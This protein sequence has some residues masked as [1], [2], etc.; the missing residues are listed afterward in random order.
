M[1]RLLLI[2]LLSTACAT[3]PSKDDARVDGDSD[4]K[5]TDQKK[6]VAAEKPGQ[7][8]GVHQMDMA[9]MMAQAAKQAQVMRDAQTACDSEIPDT[10]TPAQVAE[11]AKEREAAFVKNTGPRLDNAAAVKELTRIGSA[12]A[13]APQLQ[14]GLVDRDKPRAFSASDGTVLV[15]T[16]LV[17]KCADD[18]PL[19]VCDPKMAS[20]TNMKMSGNAKV[21]NAAAGLRQKARFS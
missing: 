14:F 16:G 18:T 21:K 1:R 7:S 8:G 15:T 2:S 17:K 13:K 3:T 6:S 20:K 9:E 11:L 4:A 10:L 12:V 19:S 5:A